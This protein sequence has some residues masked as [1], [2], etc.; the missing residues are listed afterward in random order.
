MDKN[1]PEFEMASLA[2]NKLKST[3]FHVCVELPYQTRFMDLVYINR[4]GE[5]VF[6][7][8]ELHDWRKGIQKA[9]SFL[10]TVDYAY[11]CIPKSDNPNN[12]MLSSLR[13]EGLGLFFFD[14]L[15]EFPLVE[16]VKPHKSSIINGL[17][18]QHLLKRIN[19]NCSD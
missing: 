18:K 13:K 4:N 10:T 9:K 16:F 8:F 1:K 17:Q 6:V 14:K 11:L 5:V 19:D 15:K 2:Y 7:V 12:D 3:G